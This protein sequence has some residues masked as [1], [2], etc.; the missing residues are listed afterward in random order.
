MYLHSL[1]ENIRL[2]V[3]IFE[4]DN[5]NRFNRSNVHSYPRWADACDVNY[6]IHVPLNPCK[7]HI[8]WS[9]NTPDYVAV[10]YFTLTSVLKLQ[11]RPFS[12]PQV[13]TKRPAS[14][15]W[16]LTK[17]LN[18]FLFGEKCN[19]TKDKRPSLLGGYNHRNNFLLLFS[20]PGRF[21]RECKG[22]SF[23]HLSGVLGFV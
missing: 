17:K 8:R 20:H 22:F 15:C 18:N 7:R 6:Q 4:L 16:P 10:T 2:V 13:P 3:I 21:V 1:H 14:C 11:R 9:Y 12:Q 19:H 23:V 5:V